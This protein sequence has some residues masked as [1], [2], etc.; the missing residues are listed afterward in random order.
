MQDKE[1]IHLYCSPSTWALLKASSQHSP[2]VRLEA[3]QLR[4]TLIAAM[5]MYGLRAWCPK[6]HSGPHQLSAQVDINA[7]TF[8]TTP[9]TPRQ[10]P[11]H[12]HHTTHTSAHVNL[13]RLMPAVIDALARAILLQLGVLMPQHYCGRCAVNIKW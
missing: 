6:Q 8:S 11:H 1:L 5:H 2:A 12:A 3:S 7:T 4:K 10:A 13:L 9:R